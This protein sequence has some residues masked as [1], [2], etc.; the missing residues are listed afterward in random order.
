M[1]FDAHINIKIVDFGF[2]TQ[3]TSNKV[4]TF[5]RLLSYAAPKLWSLRM[6]LY[7]MVLG[8]DFWELQKRIPSRKYHVPFF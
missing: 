1:F 5:C 3:F 8:K 2:S 4:N 6:I 7:E